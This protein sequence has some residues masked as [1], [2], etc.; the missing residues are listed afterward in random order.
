M[1]IKLRIF[2]SIGENVVV[3]TSLSALAVIALTSAQ[4]SAQPAP[5]VEEGTETILSFA[6]QLCGELELGGSDSK[7][8]L[9]GQA[10]AGI[11]VLSKRLVD[12]GI[13]GGAKLE[14]GE[15]SNVLREQLAEELKNNRGCRQSVFEKMFAVV[16]GATPDVALTEPQQEALE[17]RVRPAKFDVIPKNTRFTMKYGEKLSIGNDD[18]I[19]SL[20]DHGSGVAVSWVDLSTGERDGTPGG[21]AEGR[22]IELPDCKLILYHIDRENQSASFNTVC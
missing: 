7:L 17:G 14:D 8:D 9:D 3:K 12:L 11:S 4:L 15:Y 5:N 20:R 6:E 2:E 18:V 19:L 22:S 13:T 1:V 21:F 10:D 16:F